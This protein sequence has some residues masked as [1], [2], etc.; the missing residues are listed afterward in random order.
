MRES[1]YM[2]VWEGFMWRGNCKGAKDNVDE[3]G[4]GAGIR[5]RGVKGWK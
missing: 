2:I 1:T 5:E 4:A 3:R